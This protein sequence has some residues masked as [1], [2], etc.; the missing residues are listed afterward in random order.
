MK[1]YFKG[2][3]NVIFL[4]E[5]VDE[6]ETVVGADGK[7]MLQKFYADPAKYA[8]PFQMMAYISRLAVLKAA[9]K[10]NPHA[11]IISE[12][13]LYTDKF[14]FA[15]ML[16]DM[17]KIEDVCYQIYNQWFD[18]FASEC[19][20]EQL[21]YVCTDPA[22]CHQRTMK[23]ARVGEEG[24][25]LDYLKECHEYHEKMIRNDIQ[26][27]IPSEQLVLDGN[28]DIFQN[29]EQLADWKK[30]VTEFIGAR[31]PRLEQMTLDAI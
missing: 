29:A 8:F 17:G 1:E 5:P 20:I 25:P 19:P 16:F 27:Y 28:V 10:E 30:Q 4:K 14:V 11:T 23:R 6:W 18:T 13:S 26:V 31:M 15:K 3:E 24:I 12:R 7:A 9:I 22:I 2:D 21:I